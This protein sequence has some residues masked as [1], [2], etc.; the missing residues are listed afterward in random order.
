MDPK[1][2]VA[3]WLRRFADCVRRIDYEGGARLFSPAVLGFGTH[4]GRVSG[5]DALV[6]RQW[7]HIWP[8]TADMA[9]EIEQKV[10]H[11][12]ADNRLVCVA[13]PFT[14]NWL[15]PLGSAVSPPGARHPGARARRGGPMALPAQPFLAAARHAG[16]HSPAPG[17][18]RDARGKERRGRKPGRLEGG[19][20]E[21]DV[22]GGQEP[23]RPVV[24]AQADASERRDR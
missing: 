20:R 7:S 19:A 1:R 12:A 4:A 2:E 14:F 18:Q 24:P 10:L 5:R 15:R 13:V 3:E 16:V 8:N 6:A 22:V 11:F 17:L 23:R 21:H 9:F